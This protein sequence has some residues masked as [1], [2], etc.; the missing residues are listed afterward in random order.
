[1]NKQIAWAAL[2]LVA[3]LAP[4]GAQEPSLA[5]PEV[6]HRVDLGRKVTDAYGD[7]S[8]VEVVLPVDPSRQYPTVLF[9]HG[10]FTVPEWYDGMI[11]NLAS[12]GFAVAVF[13][14]INRLELRLDKWVVGGQNAL[15]AVFLAA[16]D[17]TSP[18]YGQLDLTR[19]GLLGHS[20]GGATSICL[21]ATD[22]RV[23]TVV[24]LAP[25]CSP[26]PSRDLFLQRSAQQ[27]VPTLV[28]G[29]ELDPIVPVEQFAWPAFQ[30]MPG[31]SR[32]YVELSRAEHNNFMDIGPFAFAVF[33]PLQRRF[34][35]T[36]SPSKHK[37]IS[38]NYATAWLERYLNV[39]A[40]AQGWTDGT[41]AREGARRD[42]LTRY[43]IR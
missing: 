22:P 10:W 39:Q 9:I 37:R 18:V 26:G 16:A 30:A 17:P 15:D 34:R 25:G 6:I 7:E 33:Q 13:H 41:Q 35:V 36:L 28:F 42:V 3:L 2:L 31:T 1:M 21:G 20:Y 14:Q 5:G 24:A 27:R 19:F 32:L 23:K 38:R 12:R 8:E 11:E 4:A 43:D 29:C 40:D